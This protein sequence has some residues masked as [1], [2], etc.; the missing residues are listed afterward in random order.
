MLQGMGVVGNLV[1]LGLDFV[2]GGGVVFLL[3]QHERM[4]NNVCGDLYF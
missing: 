3:R 1:A 4:V 2:P